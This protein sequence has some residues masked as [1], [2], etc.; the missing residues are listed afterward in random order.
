M[1]EMDEFIQKEIE[2]SAE[3][4]FCNVEAEKAVLGYIL[5]GKADAEDVSAKLSPEDFSNKGCKKIY[6]AIVKTVQKRQFPDI[7]TVDTTISELYP[8]SVGRYAEFMVQ[9]ANTNLKYRVRKVD[10]YIQILKNLAVRRRS[11][12]TFDKLIKNL[13]DPTIN[14]RETLAEINVAALETD[15]SDAIWT[16]TQ[17]VVVSTL[18]YL[19]KRQKGEIK[20]L[21]T[22][23][24]NLDNLIGGF[25]GGE[26]TVVAARPAV[27]KSAFGLNV[28]FGTS[29]DGFK[30]YFVSCEMVDIGF[31][32]RMVARQ[33]WVNGEVLRKA[34]MT[35]NDWEKINVG[36]LEL[37]NNHKIEFMFPDKNPNGMTIENVVRAVRH[38][39]AKHE[40][41]I[42]I[43]DY[44]GILRSDKKFK[45]DRD[46]IKYITSELK[47]LS[48]MANIP[49]IALC[50]VNRDAHGMLPNMSQL[51]DSGSVEQDA[52]NIIFLHA[53]EKKSDPS[54]HKDDV[55][56]FLNQKERN[57]KY[58]VLDVAKQRNGET[59]RMYMYFD[60]TLMRYVEITR[61]EEQKA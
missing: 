16:N 55:D 22:G 26:L 37:D 20:A 12:E 31:G 21:P 11:I 1:S 19:D 47:K 15:S 51:R 36:A 18:E 34:K 13:R 50:Q 44:I 25:F 46:R 32:Q 60:K 23:L 41:D 7:V 5:S 53:P 4:Q 27:G 29:K 33:S 2:G 38:L 61:Q 10:D 57:L 59:G 39:A 28:A 54:V 3:S 6:D 8:G 40:I 35:D 43:V 58:I 30:P 14:I 42:L 49:V 17:E 56:V 52:D 24:T 45:E 9:C 48:I